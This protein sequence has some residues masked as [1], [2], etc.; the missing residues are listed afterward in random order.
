MVYRALVLTCSLSLTL[1]TLAHADAVRVQGGPSSAAVKRQIDDALTSLA[2]SARVCFQ[3]EAPASITVSVQVAP[4]GQV[5]SAKQDTEGPVAQCLAGLVAVASLP[6][7]GER[8]KLRA[9]F[10]SRTLSGGSIGDALAPY[11][12]TLR[13]CQKG[14]DA[15][16]AVIEFAIEP[17][18]RVVEPQVRDSTVSEAEA[19]CLRSTMAKARL[20]SGVTTKRVRYSLQVRF[21][22]GGQASGGGGQNSQTGGLQP[23]KDGPLDGSELQKVM[24]RFKDKFNQCYARELRKNRSLAGKV[25]LR[26]TIRE[27]GTV[28]NVKIKE[29]ELNN[30]KV[31]NCVVKVGQGLRFPAASGSTRVF[32]PFLFSGR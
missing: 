14:K 19:R 15:G 24:N 17:D 31:E 29:T 6:S 21:S 13:A 32:Y 10:D 20:G 23:Q 9:I 7:T 4:N 5:S 25:V 28:R 12:D 27:D 30:K 8:Y 3:R 2:G 22:E 16:R 26:F 18:G 1:C 11:Q